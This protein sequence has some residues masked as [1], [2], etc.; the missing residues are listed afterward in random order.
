MKFVYVV[1]DG[2]DIDY[3]IN[4]VFSTL[5]AATEWVT[6]YNEGRPGWRQLDPGR[7]IEEHKLDE[8]YDPEKWAPA[9]DPEFT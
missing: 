5:A 1:T 6:K 2:P 8:L 4:A 9:S 7:C 3:C